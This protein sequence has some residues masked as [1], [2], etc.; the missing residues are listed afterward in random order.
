MPA[1]AVEF[2]LCGRGEE[3]GRPLGALI[4]ARLILLGLV[5]D[6]AGAGLFAVAGAWGA[7]FGTIDT[8]SQGVDFALG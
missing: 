1:E 5:A 4:D 8:V 7:D 3:L 2:V 6:A